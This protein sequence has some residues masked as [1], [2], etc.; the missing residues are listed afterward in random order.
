MKI[1]VIIPVY[2]CEKYLERSLDSVLRQRLDDGDELQIITVD[3]G[4]TDSSGSILDRYAKQH[5]NIQVIHQPNQGVSAARNNALDQADGDYVH[6]VDADDFLLYDNCY[7]RLLEILK[8]ADTPID[9]FRI[10][11]LTVHEGQAFQINEFKELDEIKITFDGSG[12]EFCHRL[13]FAGYACV[14]MARRALIEELKLRFNPNVRINED[15]LFFLELYN[16][17]KRL[18]RTKSALYVYY[19]NSSSVTFTKDKT[20]IDN[21]FDSL[22]ATVAVLDLYQD[23]RFKQYRMESQGKE[24][25]ERF[26]NVH[27]T[28]SEF[29]DYVKRGFDSGIFPLGK[30]HPSNKVKC[31]DWLLRHPF[32]FWL[33]LYPYRYVIS[34]LIKK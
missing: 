23:P 31:L 29:R 26:F 17:A 32:L 6:F 2:N 33:S 7:Q 19:R 9:V 5:S 8:A 14:S 30:I 11:Y 21:L 24:I 18:V 28:Y 27:L 10:H 16:Y 12:R 13:L 20:S 22:P 4:S 3:D 1:S 25:I 34:P 15:S